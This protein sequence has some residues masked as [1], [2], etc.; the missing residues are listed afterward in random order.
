M[1]HL[2]LHAHL[3]I[4]PGQ[5]EGFKTQVAEML[6]L[7]RELDTQTLRPSEANASGQRSID[8]LECQRVIDGKPLFSKDSP[9]Q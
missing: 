5:M 6:R 8:D 1:A 7:T 3:K 9:S 2:E 4:R